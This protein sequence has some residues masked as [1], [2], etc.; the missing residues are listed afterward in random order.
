LVIYV[1]DGDAIRVLHVDDEPDFAELTARYLERERQDLAVETATSASE[2]LDRLADTGSGTGPP[3]G[4][5]TDVD[6]VVSDYD[7]PGMDGLEFLKAVREEYSELPFILFTGK[8]SEEIASEAVTAGVTDYLNKGR[9][10]DTYTL[11]AN[12]IENIVSQHRSERQLRESTERIRKLYGGLT[13]AICVV[14]EDWRFTHL[15]EQA[16]A[17]LERTE[18]EL[19]GE[20]VWEQFP[21][22][23][24]TVFQEEYERAIA[25]GVTVEFEAFYPPLD[26]WVEVR[27]VP[28]D[29]GLTVQFRDISGKKEA[30]QEIQRQN[31]RLRTIVENAPVVLYALDDD[32]RFTLAEGRGLNPLGFESGELVGESVFDRYAGTTIAENAR[33]AVDGKAG[34]TSFWIDDRAFESW[35]RPIE[36]EAGDDTDG[37]AAIG[38]AVDITEREEQARERDQYRTA[39]GTVDDAVYALDSEGYFEFVNR[40]FTD[41]TGYDAAEVRGSDVEIIKDRDTAEMFEDRLREML[42]TGTR[43]ATVEFETVTKSG[44]RIP[45]ED[46]LAPRM[47]DGEFRGVCGSIRDITDRVDR[48]RELERKTDLF[49]RTQEIAGVGGWEF[50]PREDDLRWT[51]EVRRIHGVDPD[52][53]PDLETAID[54]YHPED[55]PVI[56]EAIERAIDAGESYDEQLRL[57]TAGG[58]LRWVRSLGEPTR[59][60]GETLLLWGVTQDITASKQREREL[61]HQNERLEE[62]AGVLSHDLRNPL[63]VAKSYLDLL[64][65]DETELVGKIRSA[66]DR[67][68]RIIEDVLELARQGETIGD[69][70]VLALSEMAQSAWEN[71]E[72][73]DARLELEDDL[74][75]VEADRS[76][77]VSLFEN[78]FSNA[79]EHGGEGVTCRVDPTAT[80]FYVADDG[81][82]IP[83]AERADV[84]EYGYT[85]SDAGTG[86]GLAIVSTIAEAHGWE[87][88][89]V[90]SD[91]GGARF[92]FS[93]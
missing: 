52:Y 67:I 21:E 26:V 35:Y 6:C 63:R 1:S 25:E 38:I 54:F 9:K 12:R 73:G 46:H 45:C 62:F 4:P 88:A 30:E 32:G 33:R 68:E 86:F 50:G 53:E 39:I 5:G 83:E 44:E 70:D 89:L 43:S 7:M 23:V 47:V 75:T 80:G 16:E 72:T 3:T 15:N 65:T 20:T 17:I 76:R 69:T 78:L 60:N 49:E 42:S 56:E 48:E 34:Y 10:S 82:G 2:G 77:L 81:P 55:R 28:V 29:D 58:D 71:I 85:T 14:D 19:V 79:I 90:E 57:H 91:A 64:E 27:A 84:F 36:R 22:A 18:A 59:E 41:L 11:L 93:L 37:P 24:G 74:H 8:G 13:D 87:H 31:E 92:E 51:E 40:A 61:R 66:H